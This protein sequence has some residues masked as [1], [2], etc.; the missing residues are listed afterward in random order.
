MSALSPIPR[1]SQ[2]ARATPHRSV[3]QA[4][5]RAAREAARAS[6]A[7]GEHDDEATEDNEATEDDEATEV[8][9]AQ[10]GGGDG[11]AG[12]GAVPGS[13]RK[14]ARKVKTPLKAARAAAV[15]RDA[16]EG[17]GSEGEEEGEDGFQGVETQS[18]RRAAKKASRA[19]MVLGGH[20]EREG[21]K[22]CV[23]AYMC[24]TC[25]LACACLNG[26]RTCAGVCVHTRM[27]V[28]ACLRLCLTRV[29]RRASWP[30]CLPLHA[31]QHAINGVISGLAQPAMTRRCAVFS[32]K[33]GTAH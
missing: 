7:A 15:Y 30:A 26:A 23:C 9:D 2:L 4:A 22:V 20:G 10:D 8:D 14:K 13:A 17:G 18:K 28:H 5:K 1:G 21:R 31:P 11:A 6:A 24:G 29:R 12:A 3:E 19:W 16:L 27:Q 32:S 25:G 33:Q